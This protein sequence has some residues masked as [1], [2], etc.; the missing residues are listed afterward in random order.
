VDVRAVS[1]GASDRRRQINPTIDQTTLA[2]TF[3]ASA[4][5]V[6]LGELRRAASLLSSGNP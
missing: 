6:T 5:R 4:E 3:P 2:A 1:Q